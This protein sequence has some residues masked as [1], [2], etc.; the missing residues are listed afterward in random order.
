[1]MGVFGMD[2]LE[3]VGA[4]AQIVAIPLLLIM[5]AKIDRVKEEQHREFAKI[6][7]EFK[8]DVVTAYERIN[9][10]KD[11]LH[12]QEL[13]VRDNYKTAKQTDEKVETAV[14]RIFERIDALVDRSDTRAA[15]EK[16]T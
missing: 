15:S 4:I 8:E 9:D 7:G 11:R 3:M 16:R 1:M 10:V 13:Y 2:I 6:R 14:L 12:E 5:W